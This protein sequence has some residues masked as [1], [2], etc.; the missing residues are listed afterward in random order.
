MSKKAS[1][2][3]ITKIIRRIWG[4]KAFTKAG[5]PKVHYVRTIATMSEAPTHRAGAKAMLRTRGRKKR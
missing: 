5:K 1:E 4:K 2:A 3:T